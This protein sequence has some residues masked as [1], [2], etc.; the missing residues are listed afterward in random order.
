MTKYLVD[1]KLKTTTD[2]TVCYFF[3]KDDFED[4]RSGKSAL[5]CILHQLFLQ[6]KVL[7]SDNIIKRL[8]SYKA[9]L[10]SS[11]AELWD[12]LVMASQQRD[13]GEIVCILDAFDECEDTERRKLAQALS[14]FYGMKNETKNNVNLKFLVTSRPYHK[15]SQD[16]HEIPVIHLKGESEEEALKITQEIDSYIKY[17]V[18]RIRVSLHLEIGEERLLLQ[19]PREFPNQTYLWVS[20]TFELIKSDISIDKSVIRV[21]TSSL[22]QSVDEAYERIL[23]KSTN[24]EDAKIL[25]HIIVTA[26]RPLTLEEMSLALALRQR[27]SSYEDKDLRDK[28]KPEERFRIYIRDFYGSS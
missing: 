5:S 4:Q 19:K 7:F 6:R 22:P 24:S 27:H 8:E 11:F 2:R 25:P 10:T 1:D 17:R 3:L 20:P 23:A 13:A 28:L 12:I 18:S 9:D 15:L 14:D 16:F 21:A 26:T